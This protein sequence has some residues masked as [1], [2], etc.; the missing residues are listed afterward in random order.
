MIRDG[1]NGLLANFFSPEDFADK[2]CAVLADPDAYRHLGRAAEQ[3]V[4]EK[5]SLEALLPQMLSLYDEAMSMKTGL[6]P[7]HEHMQAPVKPKA[8]PKAAG[9]FG[10]GKPGALRAADIV[11]GKAPPKGWSPFRG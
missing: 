6:E 7:M 1:E 8:A 11:T 9:P 10:G 5:Y 3:M 2:A 4:A